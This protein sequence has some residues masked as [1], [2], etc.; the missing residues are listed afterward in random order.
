LRLTDEVESLRAERDALKAEWERAAA[1]RDSLARLIEQMRTERDML[2]RIGGR[3]VV[4]HCRSCGEEWPHWSVL[5]DRPTCGPCQRKERDA[6]VKE[7]KNLRADVIR[8]GR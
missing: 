1:E 3:V 4:A 6:L 7:N 8:L 5:S 2:I